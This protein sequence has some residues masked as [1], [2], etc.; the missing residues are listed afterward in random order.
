MTTLT[1]QHFV[2]KWK[3]ATARERQAAQSH[4]LDLC[5]L[6][7]H[8]TPIDFDPTGKEFAFEMGATKA[9]G[10]QGWA[11]VAKMR[12]FAME[13]KGKHG[14]LDK[15]YVQ[16]LR[17]RD[18]LENPPL[19]IVSDIDTIIIRTNYTNYKTQVYT[20]TLDDLLT[21]H[22]MQILHDVFYEPEKLRPRETLQAVTE[23]AASEFAQLAIN[24]RKYGEDPQQV[25]HF[26]IRI[27]FC[28]FAQDIGLLPQ[29]MFAR[30]IEQTRNSSRDLKSAMQELFAKMS[31]GGYFGTA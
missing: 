5:A 20:L 28:L 6:V 26:L 2:A 15:A 27:L 12:Y 18:S 7:G 22:G 4:F 9:T 25:A 10:G 31:K 30:L 19:L 17:Y 8:P 1:P 29:G 14:N 21:S 13:Y 3:R 24:L 11:D 16:L 23:K